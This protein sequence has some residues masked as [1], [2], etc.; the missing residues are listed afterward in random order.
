MTDQ[1]VLAYYTEH[2]AITNPKN[3]ADLIDTC[4]ADPVTLA[5]VTQGLVLHNSTGSVY[6]IQLTKIQREDYLTLRS[7]ERVF[8]RICSID[9]RSILE[10]RQPA[11]RVVGNCRTF[12]TVF[13]A[14]CRQKGIPARLR[15][16]FATYFRPEQ[17]WN[18]DHW[19]A[20]YWNGNRWILLDPQIDD[21]QY[22]AMK[23]SHDVH[24]M[25]H[26]TDFYTAGEAWRLCRAKEMDSRLF[27]FSRVLN[28]LPFIK[29]NLL[30]DLMALNKVELLPWDIWGPL[31]TKKQKEM[32][33]AD[34]ARLDEI[35]ELTTAVDSRFD[36]VQ[37]MFQTLPDAR[38]TQTRLAS[39]GLGEVEIGDPD[40][41]INSQ[42]TMV[43]HQVST[44]SS[45]SEIINKEQP[46]FNNQFQATADIEI[47]GARQHNLKNIDVTI[48]RNKLVVVTGVSGSGKSSLA[49][50]TLFAEGQRRY[51]ESLSSYA[52]R[53][54]GQM[55]KPKVDHISGLSPAVAIEQKTVSKNPRSTVGTIT[56]VADHLRLLFARVGTAHCPQCG[57]DVTPQSPSQIVDQILEQPGGSKIQ[58]LAPVAQAR[59][60]THANLLEKAQKDGY[61]RARINGEM[62]RLGEQKPLAK[63]KAHDVELVI[64]RLTLP[65]DEATDRSFATRLTD[66][67]ETTLLAGNGSLTLLLEDGSEQKFSQHHA[68]GSCGLSFQELSPRLFSPNS[69]SGMCQD[70]NGLGAQLQVDPGLIFNRPDL[71]LLDG[72][73]SYYG[74]L[75]KKKSSWTLTQIKVIA[76]HYKADISQPWED[77]PEDFRHALVYGSGDVAFKFIWGEGRSEDRMQGEVTRP[78]QGLIKQIN[79]LFRTTKSEGRRRWLAQ[80]MSQLPCTSCNGERLCPE[81][82]FVTVAGKRLP[83]VNMMTLGETADWVQAIPQT[84][85]EEQSVIVEEIMIELSKRLRFMLNVGLHY[86]NLDRAAPTLSGGEGQRIRLASQL[87]SGLV[88]VLYVLDEPSIG[89]HVR[90]HTKLIE[91]L[92]ELRDMGNTVL[93]VEHDQQ[94]M[95][96][97]DWIIDLGPRA[98]VLGGELIAAGPPEALA[99]H[100]ESLTGR[101]LRGDLKIKTSNAEKLREPVGWLTLKDARLNNLKNLTVKFPLG[102]LTCITGVSGSGKSS[103]V[104]QTLSPILGRDLMNA[105]SAPGPHHSLDGLDQL[106]KA[107]NITQDPIGRTPRSNPATYVGLFDEIRKLFASLPEAKVRGYK[108]GR[109]SFNNSDGRCANCSGHGQKRVE[110][111]FLADVWVTCRECNGQ[112]FNRDTLAV[113]FKD[114]HIADVLDMDIAEALTF[115]EAQPKIKNGL[116]MLFDVGLDYLKL[117]QSAL[118]L[119]G[120]EAQRVKLAKELSRKAT[121]QTIYILDEPTTGLHFADVQVLLDVLHRLVDAGNSIIVIEHNLDVV[122]TADWIIDMGPEGGAAGGNVVAQG[123]PKQVMAVAESVTGQ[124]LQKSL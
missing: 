56:E 2:G 1:S 31:G 34:Y 27:G 109:F 75:S 62:V 105:Q 98:G 91:T 81:A 23:M 7:V 86:L 87:S 113:T 82:R 52:R 66:S 107:I 106:D 39:F 97:S 20:E 65:A 38:V 84:L 94:T 10:P 44:E 53:F 85:D 117:G 95:A 6:D 49:F 41:L 63:T 120:G 60:G 73:S 78:A 22:L 25:V 15:V 101:Y 74:V 76:E 59:K 58:L 42:L 18:D 12:A 72:A 100:P 68:C 5:K 17:N 13:V 116:Q 57:R 46:T 37:A 70:C 83:V 64:D 28:G 36:E 114:K 88:G 99:H 61:V 40:E 4:P 32:T 77:L 118:T 14:L 123:P 24:D 122:Q 93:V 119:S 69:P 108:A 111:H 50:D 16:G 80:F 103:L 71:S 33:A 54:L 115:F 48:P 121:G 102:V 11:D 92:T 104:G 67:V 3:F 9:D 96:K 8:D 26:G 124:E 19:V 29:G 55:E 79:R 51:V 21:E 90:D 112:R 30:A 35:A 47:V 89:L 110:M 45:R 43:N